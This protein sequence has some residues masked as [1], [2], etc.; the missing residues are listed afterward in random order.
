MKAQLLIPAAGMGTRLGADRPK[1]L[2]RIGG[3][4]LIAHTLERFAGLGLAKP[5]IIVAS[6]GQESAF[7]EALSPTFAA[8]D[9]ILIGGG[10][11]R[12]DSVRLGLDALDP[13]TE[14]VAIHDA[15]RPFVQPGSVQAAIEAAAECGAATA[16]IPSADTILEAGSDQCLAHTPDRTRL[17]ACQ[18]PQVFRVEVI[19][20]AHAQAQAAGTAVTDD[21][22]LVRLAGDRVRL[23]EGSKLNFKITAPEDL[24]LARLI[25]AAGGPEAL[26]N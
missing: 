20:A 5:A 15:A 26:E 13:A 2:V 6:P 4:P 25:I 11:Q 12:Q 1:A 18:T 7:A 16:A 8:G 22:T 21:A 19:R 3:K 17:W 9:F 10:A 14:I 24:A 23:V